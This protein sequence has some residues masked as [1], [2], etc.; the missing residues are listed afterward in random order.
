MNINEL[1]QSEKALLCNLLSIKGTSPIHFMIKEME[2]KG[3]NEYF[4]KVVDTLVLEAEA[5]AE[6]IMDLLGTTGFKLLLIVN[7]NKVHAQL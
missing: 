5:N 3:D 1:T 2:N 7:K 6:M 4:F